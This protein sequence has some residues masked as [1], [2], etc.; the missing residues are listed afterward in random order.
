MSLAFLQFTPVIMTSIQILGSLFMLCHMIKSRPQESKEDNIVEIIN[1]I[2]ILLTFYGCLLVQNI[3]II[4]SITAYNIGFYCI[5]IAT[6]CMISN[7][8]YF[9]FSFIRSIIFKCR[10]AGLIKI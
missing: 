10:Q 4:D 8:S 6:L 9:A 5:A 1:E 2:A 7:L 3:S